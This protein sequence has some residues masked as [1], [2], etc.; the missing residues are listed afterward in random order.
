[1]VELFTLGAKLHLTVAPS[2]SLGTGYMTARASHGITSAKLDIQLTEEKSMP[3]LTD[4]FY[5][6]SEQ[7]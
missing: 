6:Q 2:I 7:F 5:L 1:M 4:E 3:L